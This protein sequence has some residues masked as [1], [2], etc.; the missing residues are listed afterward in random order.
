MASNCRHARRLMTATALASGGPGRR[1]SRR[2]ALGVLAMAPLLGVACRDGGMGSFASWSGLG[3]YDVGVLRRR[4]EHT[5]PDTGAPRP[6]DTVV[7]YPAR[8]ARGIV[9]PARAVPRPD[10]AS[11]DGAFP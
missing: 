2:A 1:I 3:P 8:R 5:D 6:L 4:V 10:A 7:W 9:G 11:A